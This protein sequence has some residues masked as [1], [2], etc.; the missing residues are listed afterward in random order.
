M[1]EISYVKYSIR[2]CE[3]EWDPTPITGC[4]CCITM[5]TCRLEK[6][7]ELPGELSAINVILAP[8]TCTVGSVNVNGIE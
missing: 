5:R 8:R 6:S 2:V 3:I 7:G 1:H 4:V